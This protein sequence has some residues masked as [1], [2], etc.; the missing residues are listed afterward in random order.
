MTLAALTS[1]KGSPVKDTL[2]VFP[3]PNSNSLDKPIEDVIN[4]LNAVPASVIPT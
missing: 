1:S 4:P 3:I 2:I